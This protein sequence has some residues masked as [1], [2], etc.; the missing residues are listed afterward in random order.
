MKNPDP[1][2]IN[3]HWEVNKLS[4]KNRRLL[5]KFILKQ[6]SKYRPKV[7]WIS[8]VFCSDLYLLKI[9]QDFLNHN[10][11]T[12]IITFDLS[13][14]DALEAEIYISQDRVRENAR[15]FGVSV[16]EELHR[17]IFHGILHLCGFGD[18]TAAEK[19]I[20]RLEERKLIDNYFLKFV[21][22]GT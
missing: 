20:M 2:I 9:N 7:N 6:V 22:R 18:K 13:P 12:D 17:V 15:N 3:F 1:L 16:N 8:F 19:E 14:S 4:L 11:Y 10:S 5:K 21:P